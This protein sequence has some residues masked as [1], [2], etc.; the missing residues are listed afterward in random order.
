MKSIGAQLLFGQKLTVEMPS[1]EQ[2]CKRL[3]SDSSWFIKALVGALLMI[4]PG[5]H[6]LAFGYLYAM[7]EQAR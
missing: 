2:V 1:L 5:V 3:F 4:V 6:F 7:V